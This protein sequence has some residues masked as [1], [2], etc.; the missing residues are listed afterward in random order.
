MSPEVVA[1]GGQALEGV[2]DVTCRRRAPRSRGRVEG[3]PAAGRDRALGLRAA[4]RLPGRADRDAVDRRPGALGRPAADH[5]RDGRRADLR[6]GGE[7]DHRP[8]DRR[9]EPAYRQPGAGH[10]GGQRADRLDRRGRRAG[11]L[12][13]RR[14]RCSTRCAWCSSPLAVVPLVVY[15]YAK[16]FTDFP[17]ASS[18][19]PRRSRRSARGSPSPARSPAP[20]RPGCS[21]VAVGLWIGGFDLI[22][23]CQ[24]AEVDRRDRRALACRPASAC[25][26]RCTPPRSTH[27]VTF[28]LFVWFGAL[29]GLR[30]AVVDRAGADRGRVRLR[31][32][33]SSRRTTCPGSTGRSSPPTASSASRCSCS[34]C[35]TW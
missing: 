22:Y 5:G 33:R 17:H 11:G 19:S 9:A 25:A 10:R 16:R 13:R 30:L 7:P 31:A 32:R 4:V 28:G 8:A 12:P 18:R 23:A 15:P 20:V 6:D 2:R 26:P 1:T 3:V 14:R 29:V 34:P 21:G 27:V 35:S 24:D